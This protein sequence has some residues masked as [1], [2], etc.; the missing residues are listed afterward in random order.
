[1]EFSLS[2]AGGFLPVAVK[3]DLGLEFLEVLAGGGGLSFTEGQWAR[4][5]STAAHGFIGNCEFP[6]HLEQLR[7]L[8][9]FF[10]KVVKR[11]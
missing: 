8:P 4:T 3:S 1:M 7:Q 10:L 11:M 9:F 5:A 2:F 6:G